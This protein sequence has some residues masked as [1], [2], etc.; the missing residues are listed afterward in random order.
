MSRRWVREEPASRH[1]RRACCG[2][3]VPFFHLLRFSLKLIA[4]M[5]GNAGGVCRFLQF[6]GNTNSRLT[7]MEGHPVFPMEP[8]RV[9]REH[10]PLRQA[11]LWRTAV[12]DELQE[13]GEVCREGGGD[14]CLEAS[15]DGLKQMMGRVPEIGLGA[16]CRMD[17]RRV[18]E[19]RRSSCKRPVAVVCPA[20]ACKRGECDRSPGN[21]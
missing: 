20:E 4:G 12:P 6:I 8:K 9:H 21:R 17:F 19:R 5:G 2:S 14:G 10:L 7:A 15:S 13:A 1:L 11:P 3:F 18:C 16:G